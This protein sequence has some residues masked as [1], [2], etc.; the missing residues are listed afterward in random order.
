[1][2]GFIENGCR[3]GQKMD[4]AKKVVLVL[5]VI[6]GISSIF[7]PV[8]VYA[9]TD[10]LKIHQTL[11]KG[12]DVR[13]Q[14]QENE[15]HWAEN[16]AELVARYRALKSEE[17]EL[18]KARSILEKQVQA[19]QAKR[20]EAQREMTETAHIRQ[21]LQ[22][23][24]DAVILR[25]EEFIERDLPFLSQERSER[26]DSVKETLVQIDTSFAEKYR[27]VMETLKVETEYGQNVEVYQKA[28]EIH[29]ESEL[30]P[31]V[32]DILRFGR[33]A[34]F[35]RT[36]DG[37][38]VGHWDRAGAKWV[39]LPN[40]YRRHINSA[41]EIALRRRTVEMVK[42]PLGRIVPR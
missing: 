38:V 25:L 3:H 30:Q 2:I 13:R 4:A 20:A 22:S 37:K 17:K 29:G 36:P 16:K 7:L 12:I 11:V 15:D 6:A 26:I 35:F 24:L 39:A 27:R 32:A 42:L 1:M 33:L 14:T 8:L 18:Q 34:L 23:R 9:K 19:Q 41:T 31:I 28:I 21:K 5:L 40:K 10:P